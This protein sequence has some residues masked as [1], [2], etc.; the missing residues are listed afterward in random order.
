MKKSKAL[1]SIALYSL[2][3]AGSAVGTNAATALKPHS[4]FDVISNSITVKDNTL[5]VYTYNMDN[6]AT[7]G[8]K[9][10]GNIDLSGSVDVNDVT[11]L[12]QYLSEQVTFD[13]LQKFYADINSDSKIDVRDVTTLQNVLTKN[14][15]R[16]V[17]KMKKFVSIALCA[18]LAA[19]G[20]VS[21][22]AAVKQ[23][24]D[25]QILSSKITTKNNTI[26]IYTYNMKNTGSGGGFVLDGQKSGKRYK[27]IFKNYLSAPKTITMPSNE[28][29]NIWSCLSSSMG[30]TTNLD[31]RQAGG[32]YV[33][34]R[35]KLSDINPNEFKS[36]GTHSQDGHTYNFTRQTVKDGYYESVLFFQSGGVFTGAVPDSNGYVEFYV[37]TKV[38]HSVNYFTEYGFDVGLTSGGGGGTNG[39]DIYKLT[40]GNINLDYS[41]NVN[42]AS[43]LQQY[44]SGNAEF[45]SLQM[46]HADIN[47]DGKINVQDVT[48]LQNALS[49]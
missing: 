31:L 1:L 12:Q 7:G 5:N 4:G 36:N 44:L 46:Y 18:V 48:A 34:V 20:A 33:K 35:A 10:A 43:L 15:L 13:N 2:V 19:G 16:E 9:L 40:F 17:K 25:Y 47:R 22:N 30:G 21:A 6:T 37:S 29:Y 27:Y 24:K 32:E 3:V 11:A 49:E 45:D 42:D 26:S 39:I 23:N 14:K 38:D 28:K 8:I 41:V